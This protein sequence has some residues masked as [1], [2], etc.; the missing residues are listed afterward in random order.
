MKGGQRGGRG[1]TWRRFLFCLLD[2]RPNEIGSL[3][4]EARLSASREGTEREIEK[5]DYQRTSFQRDS[6]PSLFPFMPRRPV[7]PRQISAGS[8]GDASRE[9]A[10]KISRHLR[11]GLLLRPRRHRYRPV[12]ALTV[13]FY[14]VFFELSSR[15]H[16]PSSLC[17]FFVLQFR[18]FPRV[19][20]ALAFYEPRPSHCSFVR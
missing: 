20:I 6:F 17:P 11:P 10:Y 2:A 18:F 1:K 9:F 3:I 15:L 13:P 12:Y 16:N 5:S 14:V 4:W 8:H 7:N 19:F